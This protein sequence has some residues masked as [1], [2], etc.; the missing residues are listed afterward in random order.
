[1]ASLFQAIKLS[2]LVSLRDRYT[3]KEP[4]RGRLTSAAGYLDLPYGSSRNPS[5][6]RRKPQTR[7]DQVRSPARSCRRQQHNE[8]NREED[9]ALTAPYPEPPRGIL[10]AISDQKQSASRYTEDMRLKRRCKTP[11]FTSTSPQRGPKTPSEF[12]ALVP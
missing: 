10:R 1:M 6:S 9:F 12:Q 3:P 11:C 5:S 7:I 2:R 4:S 8:N